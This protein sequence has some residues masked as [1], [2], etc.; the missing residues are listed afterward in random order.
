MS[1]TAAFNVHGSVKWLTD[2]RAGSSLPCPRI[3]RLS[4]RGL[5]RVQARQAGPAEGGGHA[6]W[7]DD[8]SDHRLARGL[9]CARQNVGHQD[10]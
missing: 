1:L 9:V 3:S 2:K 6:V 4:E 7:R 10:G 8:L 5:A